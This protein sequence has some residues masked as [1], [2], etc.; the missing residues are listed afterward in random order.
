MDSYGIER[1]EKIHVW[2]GTNFSSEDDYL[3]Y[4]E[5]DYSVGSDD[6]TY[7]VCGFCRD[8]GVRWYDEDFIGIIPR[9]AEEVSLDEILVES[10]VDS[11]SIEGLKAECLRLNITKA[12]AIFWYS[13][14]GTDIS[15]P[16]KANY[17][18]LKYAGL[19]E[20]E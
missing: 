12:N 4:F 15:K 11:R 5:L 20:G 9:K 16:L 14:G 13:D 2:V 19:Y 18:G 3:K 17:N 8:I 6:P 10:A 7:K 1:Y